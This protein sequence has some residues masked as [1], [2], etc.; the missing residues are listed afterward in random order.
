L[1]GLPDIRVTARSSPGFAL[2][3][4]SDGI[5]TGRSI[6]LRFLIT[7]EANTEEE[8]LGEIEEDDR[9][10]GSAVKCGSLRLSCIS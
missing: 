5:Y 2:R 3:S 1:D 6:A 4:T 9:E 7:D 10:I 8:T